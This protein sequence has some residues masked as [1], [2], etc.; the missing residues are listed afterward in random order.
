MLKT[1]LPIFKYFCD[2]AISKSSAFCPVS[3]TGLLRRNMTLLLF[4][5]RLTFHFFCSEKSLILRMHR[6]KKSC[7]V[8]D[9]VIPNFK[10]ITGSRD[11]GL[12]SD[13]IHN[14]PMRKILSTTTSGFE[15]KPFEQ[16]PNVGVGFMPFPPRLFLISRGI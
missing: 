14:Q 5:F 13:S 9:V 12:P 15:S 3:I 6:H 8:R 2:E 4:N 1:R 16:V 7:V 11:C 10:I